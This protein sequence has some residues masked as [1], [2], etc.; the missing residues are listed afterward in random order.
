VLSKLYSGLTPQQLDA[1]EAI[2]EIQEFAKDQVVFRDGEPGDCMFTVLRGRVAISKTTGAGRHQLLG[3]LGAGEYFG[4][5]SVIDSQPRSAEATAVEDVTLRRLRRADL[6]QLVAINPQILFNLLHGSGD[7]LRAMNRAFIEQVVHQEKM[8]LVGNMASS[9]IH[10]FKNPM[11]VIRANAEIMGQDPQN[12]MCARVIMRHVDRLT[13]MANDLL[14]FA[15][16]A[17]RLNTQDVDPQTWFAELD[18]LLE[19]L[20]AGR[21]I[22]LECSVLTGDHLRIDPD[23]MT[24][25]IYNLAANAV[26]AM[27][28]G[29]DLTLR[30]SKPDDQFHIEVADTGPGI[31]EEIRAR[32][33]DA[34]VTF[35]KKGGTGLGT[36]IAKK[37]VEDHGGTISFT[38]EAGRGTTFHILLPAPVQT[39]KAQTL[40]GQLAAH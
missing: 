14:D 23:R 30:L 3:T 8:A 37:T 6:N 10:D 31:P 21:A 9:I 15:R 16:G 24:R 33:F 11:T 36:S 35:G 39:P 38:T 18:E 2:G 7:R 12:A 25:A 13:T 28:R 19:P 5:M 20:A 1:A 4:E 27:P 32:L 22:R 17:V 26:E 29:G 40:A 34:F